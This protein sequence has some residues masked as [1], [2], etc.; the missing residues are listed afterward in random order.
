MKWVKIVPNLSEG[1]DDYIISHILKSLVAEN[2]YVIDL[3]CDPSHNRTVVTAIC[4][5]ENFFEVAV[6]F[7]ARCIQYIDLNKHSG[8]H[9]RIGALDVFPFVNFYN[10]DEKTISDFA[11]ELSV[12]LY[13]RFRLPTYFYGKLAKRKIKLSEL[14]NQG[15]KKLSEFITNK[16]EKYLPDIGDAIHPTAGAICIGIREE[17][18]AYNIF[19]DTPDVSIARN[20]ANQIRE[21]NNGLKGVQA[22]GFF[23]EHIQKAQVSMNLTNYRTTSIKQV[24]DKVKS[25]AHQQKVDILKSEIVGLVP[26][27][28]IKDF[29]PI[30]IKLE[31]FAPSQIFEY[32]LQKLAIF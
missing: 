11:N 27:D 21:T 16:N 5:L 15:L 14:R 7:I 18:I 17:L 2:S 4:N 8:V 23:I 29:N 28:A 22:L 26:Y 31:N 19:L 20:I 6:D 12:E 32:H 1:K 30:D 9:P 10:L 24:Y 13:K 3:H 25:L